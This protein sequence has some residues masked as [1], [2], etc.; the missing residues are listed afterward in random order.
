[1]SKLYMY[2]FLILL[3]SGSVIAQE[4]DQQLFQLYVNEKIQ[5][6]T[7]E[8]HTKFNQRFDEYEKFTETQITNFQDDMKL[9]FNRG[10]LLA[11]VMV[12]LTIFFSQSVWNWM[13]LRRF[14]HILISLQE[15]INKNKEQMT[16]QSDEEPKPP[17]PPK[18]KLVESRF[19]MNYD[20]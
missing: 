5:Q 20:L 15:Q 17:K 12:L 7:E 6:Q 3:I 1:M 9:I 19:N 13:H 16:Q 18:A 14:K 8:F 2:V 11:G 10:V 4:C